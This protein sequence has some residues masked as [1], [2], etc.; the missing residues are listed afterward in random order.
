M[1][2]PASPRNFFP[3]GGA[4]HTYPTGEP[5]LLPEKMPLTAEGGPEAGAGARK[6]VAVG[7]A[8]QNRVK[9]ERERSDRTLRRFCGANR[10]GWRAPAAAGVHQGESGERS[11]PDV[12]SRGGNDRVPTSPTAGGGGVGAAKSGQGGEGAKR[13]DLEAVLRSGQAG[14]GGRRRRHESARAEPCE[15]GEGLRNPRS[16]IRRRQATETCKSS[17]VDFRRGRA[18]RGNLI[19]LAAG[20]DA[21]ADFFKCLT[22]RLF[23]LEI[24]SLLR[25]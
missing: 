2:N 13:P 11:G 20:I 17:A 12:G 15:P 21:N 3:E 10:R 14:A 23:N 1:A 19:N 16:G 18:A 7:W 24:G 6:P 4:V 8:E 25:R 9:V 5:P 22:Q